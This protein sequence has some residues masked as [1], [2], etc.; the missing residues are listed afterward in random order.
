MKTRDPLLLIPTDKTNNLYKLS[1]DNYNKL[2]TDNITKS[3]KK[4]QILVL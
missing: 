1:K 4:K 2:L 3:H